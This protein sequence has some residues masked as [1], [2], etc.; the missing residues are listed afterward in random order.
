MLMNKGARVSVGV[1]GS[2]S[3]VLMLCL[4]WVVPAAGQ[5]VYT[6][7]ED[8][9]SQT[10]TPTGE[11]PE[12][13][14]FEL[15]Q[16]FHRW[17]AVAVRPTAD[18]NWAIN[19]FSDTT[20]EPLCV[21][22]YVGASEWGG[23][24]VDF[25]IGDF[26]H[27]DLG[28]YYANVIHGDAPA[29]SAPLV[30]WDD[31]SDLLVL[32]DT[33][34]VGQA[35][36]DDVIQV[37]DVFLEAGVYYTFKL[38]RD[39][40]TANRLY[41]FHNPA[42]APYWAA[43]GD[44]VLTTISEA[45]YT[46]PVSDWYGVVVVNG[47]SPEY[48][49]RVGYGICTDPYVLQSNVS[50]TPPSFS[51]TYQITLGAPLWSA[52]GYRHVGLEQGIEAYANASI[53]AWPTCL[54]NL[55]FGHSNDGN[56]AV[57]ASYSA[58]GGPPLPSYLHIERTSGGPPP[59][60]EWQRGSDTIAVDDL[61]VTGEMTPDDVIRVRNI[62][63]N[64]GGDY[65]IYFTPIGNADLQLKLY[66]PDVLQGG[67]TASNWITETDPQ[68]YE[69]PV[70]GYYGLVV[71]NADGGFGEY[72]LAVA[73]CPSAPVELAEETW[74]ETPVASQGEICRF[75][76]DTPHWFAVAV[77]CFENWDLSLY[78]YPTGGTPPECWSGHLATS[79]EDTHSVDFIVG[80]GKRN[81][82]GAYY[83]YVYRV[84]GVSAQAHV[85]WD[86]GG[87]HVFPDGV[88][89]V[90]EMEANNI[91]E[92][93]DIYLIGGV[94]YNIGIATT[95]TADFTFFVFRSTGDP[96]FATR[97]DA[98]VEVK[99]S[100]S[101]TAPA[102]GW[103]GFVVVNENGG[104]GTFPIS[105]TPV[106]VSAEGTP[107]VSLSGIHS[108][109]PN[110][111]TGA[112]TIHFGLPSRQSVAFEIVDVAGRLIARLPAEN[113]S[114]GSWTRSWDG[115]ASDGN[116]PPSGVYFVRMKQAGRTVGEKRMVLLK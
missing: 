77:S 95:G 28:A 6:H 90:G 101:Y 42:D 43:P 25:I 1:L 52:V 99:G 68:E 98:E 48:D 80:N 65:T 116:R 72:S 40:P 94:T 85:E 47:Y 18:D 62:Y 109:V 89:L 35:G 53:G 112:I 73:S 21:T 34:L 54:S 66:K 16:A 81:P 97:A 111:T 10:I 102:T 60:L 15:D 69:A 26:Y 44:E 49:Y 39:A 61:P 107:A 24:T 23:W 14:Y 17:G 74:N 45:N 82:L 46:A 104:S 79:G 50:L 71:V 64:E 75:V 87:T 27:N 51:N 106:G 3:T 58:A 12:Y 76:Q 59:V 91:I 33:L 22:N 88:Q 30:E 37:Y 31:G 110:P 78:E 100:T 84:E 4:F 11:D 96:Y 113:V 20:T 38:E 32:N 63:F 9:V 114:A 7:L 29:P 108:L 36:N 41:L 93:T 67:W 105:V 19:L 103:Y 2:G 83:P 70:S 55:V 5:C 57:M 86:S 8:N 13:H 115:F 92:L 56:V